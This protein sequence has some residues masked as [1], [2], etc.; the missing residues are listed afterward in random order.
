MFDPS[1]DE[2]FS[3][4]ES[5]RFDIPQISVVDNEKLQDMFTEKRWKSQFSKWNI[6]KLQALMLSRGILSNFLGD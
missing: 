5:R 4:N 3:L 2:N 6:T 1:D